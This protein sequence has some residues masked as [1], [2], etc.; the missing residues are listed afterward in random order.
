MITNQRT[1]SSDLEIYT[2]WWLYIKFETLLSHEKIKTINSDIDS[3]CTQISLHA[4]L[5]RTCCAGPTSVI[6]MIFSVLCNRYLYCSTWC[7]S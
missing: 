3:D 6:I 4:T 1:N 5:V 7:K 2:I